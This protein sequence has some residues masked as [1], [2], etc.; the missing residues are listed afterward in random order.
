MKQLLYILPLLLLT[1][2]RVAINGQ[3]EVP[4]NKKVEV[5]Y[6][7]STNVLS[8]V[9]EA[10]Q[11]CYRAM[12]TREDS[13]AIGGEIAWVKGNMFDSAFTVTAPLYHQFTFDA[14]SLPRAQF[15]SVY[16]LVA[17]EMCA[18]FDAYMDSIGERPYV[19][20]GFS[21]GGMLVLELLRHMT[22][23]QYER[24]V[25]AYAMGYR[26]SRE[27][28]QH[29]HIHAAVCDS[30]RGVVI[31]YNS[32][33]SQEAIW[34][35]VAGEAATCINPL[36]WRTDTV[37]ASF[38]YKGITNRIHLD[39]ETQVLMVESDHPE[40]YREWMDRVGVFTE[41]GVSH[42]C[43]HHWDLLFYNQQIHDNALKRAGRVCL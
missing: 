34:P 3:A 5:F 15:D 35:F 16:G 12:L 37:S 9:D 8:A 28:L 40:V 39:P 6:I 25:A 29:P 22:D 42:D 1:G 19:L 31:S 7:A 26:L 4:E 41:L 30:D 13:A 43:L 20:A 21:Q 27:D 38:E 18:R 11:K 23:E 24:M 33:L 2:C 17:A 36:N 10:G 14:I 32:V